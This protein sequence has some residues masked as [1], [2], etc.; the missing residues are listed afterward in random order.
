MT[1]AFSAATSSYTANVDYGDEQITVTA[2]TS[3]E[4]TGVTFLDGDGHE[5]ADADDAAPGQQVDLDVGEN[6]IKVR[7]AGQDGAALETYTIAMVRAKP[8]VSIST[9]TSEV[10]EGNNVVFTVSRNAGTSEALPVML[11]VTETGAMVMDPLKGEGHRSVTVPSHATSTTL[12]VV[13]DMDDDIWEAHS[14]VNATITTSNT[15]DIK[16]DEGS[17]ETRVMDND[18]PEA[19][20]EL[21]V[22]PSVVT[23]GGPVTAVV[24]VKTMRDEEPHT[25]GGTIQVVVTGESATSDSDFIPP[26]SSESALVF[27]LIDFTESPT[28][29]G[30]TR[31]TASK[32][33]SIVTV[34]DTEDEGPETFTIEQVGVVDGDSPT[35]SQ[36][37]LD[38]NA[39]I[40]VV[41][42]NDNDHGQTQTGGGGQDDSPSDDSS[43]DS[44][45]SNEIGRGSGG[46][47]S[48]RSSSNRRPT[49]DEGDETT[50]SVAENSPIGTKVGKR[51]YATD[52]DGDRLT[53][54][55]SGDDES[56]F[57]V[58]EVLGQLRTNVELDRETTARYYVTVTVSDGK[59][60]SD[61]IEVTIIVTDVDEAPNVKGKSVIS[62][63]EG[64]TTVLGTYADDD[65]ENGVI[66]WGLSGDDAGA[67]FIDGGSLTFRGPPDYEAPADANR[68]NVYMVTVEASDGA[69]TS[70]LEVAVTVS[71]LDESPTPTSTPVPAPTP[72]ALPTVTPTTVPSPTTTFTP[73]PPTATPM[74][75][76]TH[77][78]VPTSTPAPTSMPTPS[79]MPTPTGTP[80]PTPAPSPMPTPTGTPTPTPTATQ[81]PTPAPS[82][83]PTATAVPT[84]ES[85]DVRASTTPT[86]VVSTMTP[87][88]FTKSTDGGSVPAW[89]LLSIT[90]WAILATGVSVY[91]YLSQR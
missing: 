77:T 85:T 78:V 90:A 31:Y 35:A 14:T 52:G 28:A 81:T 62:H 87:V 75:T 12:T 89:L 55:L 66:D 17:A 79:P 23:E 45:T 3:R 11:S 33:V 1:P 69:H 10:I 67:F 54:S 82:P 38:S 84:V 19:T 80:T 39:S 46:G 50:R 16:V 47:G 63:M 13:T 48:G 49:F 20:A 65:P 70:A 21:A 37:A 5:I 26:S 68:D 59:G 29:N 2:M 40:R 72:T 83:S 24:T 43:Q 42:V 56:L 15:Y 64:D 9:T 61:S 27:A 6:V 58:T 32:Q 25:D 88:S 41:T 74:P 22:S 30:E 86:S 76:M 71:D 4:N 60:G 57:T 8:E 73:V 91:V 53:Y 36:I 7:V 18:F 44:A 34:D 51:V